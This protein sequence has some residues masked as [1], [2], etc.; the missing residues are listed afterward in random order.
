MFEAA[1][2]RRLA[3][4]F[5]R[6]LELAAASPDTPVSLLPMLG[7]EEART[8]MAA[9]AGIPLRPRGRP[10]ASD[11]EP[12]I[13]AALAATV[14][15]TPD[16]TALVAEDGTLS[17]AGLAAS[18]SRIAAAL[19]GGGSQ[20]RR[21]GVRA[22]APF[23]GN[24]REHV[25]RAGRR[26]RLQPDRH[27]IPGRAGLC[28]HRGRRPAGDP[29][30]PCRGGA[31]LDSSS[32]GWRSGRACWCWKTSRQPEAAGQE[33][34]RNR[35]ARDCRAGRLPR[36]GPARAGLRHVHVRLHR[37]AEGRRGQPRRPGGA[38]RLPPRDACWPASNTG[39]SPTRRASAST[40]PGTRSSGWWPATS[41]T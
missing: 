8:L 41:C 40:P 2:A 6:F 37:P 28:H 20:P 3:D 18:A 35:A 15:A 14:R 24:G 7:D 19:A 11:A 30:Q 1:T 17:F 32:R 12:G 36:A 26:R 16:G 39:A 29:Y 21:R 25:R 34:R 22:A 9:T 13:L 38:A 5:S 27:R 4:S 10:A 31:G 23:T 33:A